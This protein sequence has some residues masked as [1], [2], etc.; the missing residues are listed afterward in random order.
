M[1]TWTYINIKGQGHSVTLVQGH[2]DS[3]FFILGR[4]KPS[5]MFQHFQTSNFFSWKTA[6]PIEAKFHL[7]PQW[8]RGTKICSNGLGHMTKMAT[9]SIYSNNMKNSSSLEPKGRG[10]WT[11]VCCIGYSSSTKFIQMMTLGWPGPIL[12]QGQIWSPMRLYGK[13]VKTM[14]FPETIIVYDIKLVGAVN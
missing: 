8:D 2:S 9:M 11:F 13:K 3:T 6:R 7:E 14:D 12:W 5:F 4:L 1:S 10:P